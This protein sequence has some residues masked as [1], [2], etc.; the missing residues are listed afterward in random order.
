MLDKTRKEKVGSDTVHYV[1]TKKLVDLETGEQFEAQT[2]VKTIGD[3][4]FKKMFIG[5]VL[6][7]LDGFSS[8]KLKFILWI[9]ENADKQ[10]RIIGTYEQLSIQSGISYPTVARLVPILRDSDILRVMSPS[11]YMI[12][13]DLVASVSSN[14][15]SNLLVKYKSIESQQ[16]F[17]FDYSNDD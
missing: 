7:K 4:D 6:D 11:V 3:K 1:G 12:N 17:N 10:N 13:P 14:T 16:N 2:I 9:L 5:A 15:R 8:A